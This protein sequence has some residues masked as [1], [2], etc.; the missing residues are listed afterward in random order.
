MSSRSKE[1]HERKAKYE[2]MKIKEEG[3]D[4][5][6]LGKREIYGSPWFYSLTSS[7]TMLKSLKIQMKVKTRKRNHTYEQIAADIE[8]KKNKEKIKGPNDW[9]NRWGKPLSVKCYY[10]VPLRL[11]TLG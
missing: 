2:K 1:K 9:R 7:D 6:E 3:T 10:F 5:D 11:E 4:L 8:K